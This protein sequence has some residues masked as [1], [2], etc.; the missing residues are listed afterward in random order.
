[1]RKRLPGYYRPTEEEF[2]RI[3][4]NCVFVFDANVLLNLY[5]YSPDTCSEMIRV[6]KKISDR[7]WIPHQTALEFHKHRLDIPPQQVKSYEDIQADIKNMQSKI[8][9]N[10]HSNRHPFIKN[11]DS[12]LGKAEQI[13]KKNRNRI[14]K[15]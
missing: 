9:D 4:K 5:R 10:L 14:G 6:L 7:L 11:S 2:E 3:W 1:M 12:L 8:R 13:F 15:T